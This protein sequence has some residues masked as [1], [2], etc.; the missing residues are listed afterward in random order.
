M[1]WAER[2]IVPV[3]EFT[4]TT[5]IVLVPGVPIINGLMVEGLASMVKSGAV[6]VYVTSGALCVNPFPVPFTV[7]VKVPP[8]VAVHDNVDV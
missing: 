4:G 6:I 8:V 1:D 3:N 7:T 2:S 5:V